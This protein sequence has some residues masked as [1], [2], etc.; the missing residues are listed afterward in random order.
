MAKAH[1]TALSAPVN[2]LSTLGD[3]PGTHNLT[4][5]RDTGFVWRRLHDEEDL[6]PCGFIGDKDAAP[7]DLQAE[8]DVLL[9][10][11]N[12]GQSYADAC[13]RTARAADAGR[14]DPSNW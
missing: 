4:M 14:F 12:D 8:W 10:W 11:W 3:D 5:E 9:D 13:L 6:E 2:H 1:L 7:P